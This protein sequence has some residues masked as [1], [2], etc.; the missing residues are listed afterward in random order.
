[1]KQKNSQGDIDVTVNFEL[2]NDSSVNIQNIMDSIM[3]PLKNRNDFLE[4][5]FAPIQKRQKDFLPKSYIKLIGWDSNPFKD[6]L[7]LK[8]EPPIS[9]ALKKYVNAYS[10]NFSEELKNPIQQFLHNIF[11]ETLQQTLEKLSD[12]GKNAKE[13]IYH[14]IVSE[15][16]EAKWFPGII[17]NQDRILLE[18]C[19]KVVRETRPGK[20]RVKMLD[21]AV[22]NYYNKTRLDSIRKAWAHTDLPRY[23]IRMLNEAM[24]A[25][26][27][28]DYGVATIAFSSFAQNILFNRMNDSGRRRGD[29]AKHHMKKL[30]KEYGLAQVFGSFYD[31]YI[32]SQ[33]KSKEDVLPDVPGRNGI[34]H[35]WFNGYITRKAALNA[36]LFT[37]LLIMLPYI[38]TSIDSM[39]GKKK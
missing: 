30:I 6:A 12:I 10:F 2:S 1:M 8:A 33:C 32:M 20:K 16:F 11:P 34:S 22:F 17:W 19:Y 36:I 5:L 24:R 27:N 35:G 25:Y 38:D 39:M 31:E 3:E 15:A 4:E 14:I 18:E 9:D 23:E 29:K 21:D 37:N 26:N 7:S 28:K 13:R